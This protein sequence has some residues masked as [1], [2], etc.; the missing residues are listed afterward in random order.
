[1]T[2]LVPVAPQQIP[3]DRLQQILNYGKGLLEAGVQ[4]GKQIKTGY[5]TGERLI[6]DP[7]TQTGRT[8]FSPKFYQQLG[9]R[10]STRLNS[11]H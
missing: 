7:T 8:M 9:D 1:M 5:F 4:I 10:K 2:A 3:P 6:A 11:S